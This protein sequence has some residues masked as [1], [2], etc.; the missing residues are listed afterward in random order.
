MFQAKQHHLVSTIKT[1]TREANRKQTGYG[2]PNKTQR[3]AKREGMGGK[4]MQKHKRKH[5]EGNGR[6]NGRQNYFP[7]AHG[8][9]I[10]KATGSKPG[11]K[12]NFRGPMGKNIWKA[13][14]G[15]MG[16]NINFR[17]PMGKPQQAMGSKNV[18][19]NI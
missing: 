4:W 6:Q 14:G 13:T 17:G 18:S 7:G 3:E 5:R 8:K 11:G 15:K 2:K 10:W 9:N 16:G 1:N 19:E 12:I